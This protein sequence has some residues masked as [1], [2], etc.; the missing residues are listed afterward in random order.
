MMR[1][2]RPF[3]CSNIGLWYTKDLLVR[4]SDW[5]GVNFLISS[6]RGF[7]ITAHLLGLNQLT[8][9][10]VAS[11]LNTPGN[12]CRQLEAILKK[13]NAKSVF[14]VVDCWLFSDRQQDT[15][16]L[17]DGNFR[18]F[19]SRHFF[20]EWLKEAYLGNLGLF[21]GAYLTSSGNVLHMPWHKNGH[22]QQVEARQLRLY[23][24]VICPKVVNE[25]C[26]LLNE[27][28]ERGVDCTLI[29]L[30]Y[31][32]TSYRFKS[33]KQNFAKLDKFVNSFAKTCGCK[34]IGS[35]FPPKDLYPE[36]LYDDIHHNRSGLVKV[37]RPSQASKTEVDQ[38]PEP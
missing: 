14:I 36:D 4:Q 1:G 19:L 7:F 23:D 12:M 34:V 13:T 9:L 2:E 5:G 26:R 28:R 24:V 20:M 33:I 15:V 8:V 30:P 16:C 17:M 18:R 21:G 11:D 25:F 10:S 27:L 6:S 29:K 37:L 38:Q 35:L 31:H 32:P 22:Y 3:V